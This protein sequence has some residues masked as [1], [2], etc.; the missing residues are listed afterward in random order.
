MEGPRK[1]S[2]EGAFR[3]KA[4]ACKDGAT[5]WFSLKTK[6]GKANAEQTGKYYVCT[7]AIAMTDVSDI[8]ACKVIRKL[9]MKEVAQVLEGP[10]EQE[11]A[12]VHRIRCKSLKDGQEGWITIRGNKGTVYAEESTK[13]YTLSNEVPLHK[14]FETDGATLVRQLL[15]GEAVELLEGPKEE[16]YEITRLKA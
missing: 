2:F 4:K 15:Q 16:K 12:G 7:A 1:D 14:Q 9:D 6:D 11:E 13:L 5:G 10:V 8:K 3:A